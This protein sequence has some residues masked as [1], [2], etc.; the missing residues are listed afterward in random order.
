MSLAKICNGLF[1]LSNSICQKRVQFLCG[2]I[3]NYS[4]LQ[5]SG[6]SVQDCSWIENFKADILQKSWIKDIIEATVSLS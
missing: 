1:K 3:E 4:L 6:E 5:C 2:F